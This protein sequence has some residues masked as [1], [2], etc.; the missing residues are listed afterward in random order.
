MSLSVDESML[1]GSV[2]VIVCG[3]SLN[4]VIV[5]VPVPLVSVDG[6]GNTANG[7]VLVN[8]RVPGYVVAT[9]PP[10]SVS[11]TV[12][13]NEVPAAAVEGAVRVGFASPPDCRFSA[14]E[15]LPA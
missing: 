10:F 13:V 15:V 11:V 6:F 2:T 7:S 5:N 1:T 9:E 12:R 3:P 8:V 14:V 4:N